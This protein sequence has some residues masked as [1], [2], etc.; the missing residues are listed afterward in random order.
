MLSAAPVDSDR[1]TPCLGAPVFTGFALLVLF[2]IG[3]DFPLDRWLDDH[4]RDTFPL[5][6][7]AFSY[8]SAYRLINQASPSTVAWL[9]VASALS[10]LI[11]QVVIAIWLFRQSHQKPSLRWVWSVF[12]LFAGFWGL[13][14]YLLVQIPAVAALFSPPTSYGHDADA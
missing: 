12:G 13:A 2:G 14:I 10:Y 6:H 4:R 3:V 11:G 5:L 1:I 7:A 8:L 9:S